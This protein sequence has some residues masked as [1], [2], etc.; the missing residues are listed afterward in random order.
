MKRVI[1]FTLLSSILFLGCY[2]EVKVPKAYVKHMK[3]AQEATNTVHRLDIIAQEEHIT[4]TE[5]DE[6][7]LE[8]AQKLTL[9][10]DDLVLSLKQHEEQRFAIFI[11]LLEKRT[12]ALKETVKQGN[13]IEVNKH[14]QA[15]E[16][17]CTACHSANRSY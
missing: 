14:T 2:K 8:K 5:R 15:V 10:L 12:M 3:L 16:A 6:F 4:E 13:S 1:G 17:V 7:R 11:Q 9:L